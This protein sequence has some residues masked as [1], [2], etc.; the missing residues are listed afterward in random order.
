MLSWGIMNK[1]SVNVDFILRA[2]LIAYGFAQSGA[3]GMVEDRMDMFEKIK[4]TPRNQIS[5][6]F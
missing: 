1:I 4:T 5:H 3:E 6:P 2:T